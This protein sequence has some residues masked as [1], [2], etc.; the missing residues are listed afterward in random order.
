MTR[1][2]QLVL[3]LLIVVTGFIVLFAGTFGHNI[4]GAIGCAVIVISTILLARPAKDDS[5]T[6]SSEN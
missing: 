6:P 2:A 5:S 1:R 3:S 4:L